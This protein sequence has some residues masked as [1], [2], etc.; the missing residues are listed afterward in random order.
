MFYRHWLGD[1]ALAVLLVLPL[2]GFAGSRP[3]THRA[4]PKATAAIAAANLSPAGRIGL[5]G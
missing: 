5:F 3:A 1:L 2:S 4:T